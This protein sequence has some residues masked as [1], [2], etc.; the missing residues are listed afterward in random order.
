MYFMVQYVVFLFRRILAEK[1]KVK[2]CDIYYIFTKISV[3][4]KKF[5]IVLTI[6]RC[7]TMPFILGGIIHGK[8]IVL[9]SYLCVLGAP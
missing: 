4:Y 1:E 2:T 9:S 3:L 7:K 5:G 8:L 6:I